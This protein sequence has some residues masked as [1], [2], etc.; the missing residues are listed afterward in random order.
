MYFS[1]GRL[2]CSFYHAHFRTEVEEI[3]VWTAKAHLAKSVRGVFRRV[4]AALDV[5][6]YPFG[7][8]GIG[9][10]NVDVGA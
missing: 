9:I 2:R 7:V 3:P 8:Q 10:L 4:Q 5:R 6:C 1:R